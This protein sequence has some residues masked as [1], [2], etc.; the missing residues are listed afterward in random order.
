MHPHLLLPKLQLLLQGAQLLC[1]L[2]CTSSLVAVLNQ[3]EKHKGERVG[4]RKDG[5]SVA[6][7][8]PNKTSKRC[9]ALTS[10]AVLRLGEHQWKIQ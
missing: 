10:M 4:E 7:E 2:H 6:G 3:L 5:T 8:G 1:P 9:S